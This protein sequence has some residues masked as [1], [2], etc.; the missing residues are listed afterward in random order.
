MRAADELLD[1]P[2]VV[3]YLDMLA[4]ALPAGQRSGAAVRAE[5]SDGLACAIAARVERGADPH[6]AAL[7]AV[8]EFGDPLLIA[9]AFA[10]E[11]AADSAHRIGL[12]LVIGGPLG[13]VR[14][15]QRRRPRRAPVGL[16]G[17]LRRLRR[18]RSIRCCWFRW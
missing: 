10:P 18:C 1:D 13:G 4:G 16:P 9:R 7:A 5:L 8:I 2:V 17:S 15:W 3:A 6:A 11:L 14:G 12:G